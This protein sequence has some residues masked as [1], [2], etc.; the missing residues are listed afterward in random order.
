MTNR[1]R[2]LDGRGFLPLLLCATAACGGEGGREGAFDRWCNTPGSEM[3]LLLYALAA[4]LIALVAVGWER[5]RRL[6]A[7]DLR[8]S[9][10]APSTGA[11]VWIFPAAFLVSGLVLSF[12]LNAAENCEPGQ[13]ETNLFFTWLGILLAA[14]LCLLGLLVANWSYTRR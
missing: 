9:P 1:S 3:S 11:M 13:I 4:G 14:L 2:T 6:D 7:W 10:G 12:A 8:E 5:K